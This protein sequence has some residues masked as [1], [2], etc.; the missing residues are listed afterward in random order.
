MCVPRNFLLIPRLVRCY[1]LPKIANMLRWSH[2]N[3][4]TNGKMY[5]IHDSPA[6]HA[7]DTKFS[8]FR[9]GFPNIRMTLFRDGFNPSPS[10]LCQWSTWPIFVFIY[11]LSPWMTIKH[12]FVIPIL[13]ILGK[14]SPHGKNIDV[15]IK[16]VIDQ[17]DMIW[18]L[19]VWVDGHSI[20]PKL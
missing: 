16:P 7:V 19:G 13:L 1:K 20:P 14:Y 2:L 15:Y 10:F 11:N 5:E 17:H 4:S 12:F 18:W 6:C 8:S 3:K 9:R